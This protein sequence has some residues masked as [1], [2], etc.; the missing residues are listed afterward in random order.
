MVIARRT[1]QLLD[2][3]MLQKDPRRPRPD[4][5]FQYALTAKQVSCELQPS[6]HCTD[7]WYVHHEVGAMRKSLFVAAIAAVVSV[8]P[9][10]AQQGPIVIGVST[11]K[12]GAAATAS[13]WEMWGVELAVE[14]INAAGGV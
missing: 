5:T 14:E 13:E 4:F 7:I 6:K 3:S 1:L 10:M 8:A 11:P 9:A 2:H 12:T